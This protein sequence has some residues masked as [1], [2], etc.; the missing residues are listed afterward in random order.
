MAESDS[1]IIDIRALR[2]QNPEE[3]AATVWG[4][5]AEFLVTFDSTALQYIPLEPQAPE[6]ETDFSTYALPPAI[7]DPIDDLIGFLLTNYRQIVYTDVVDDTAN[8]R[9]ITLRNPSPTRLFSIPQDVDLANPPVENNEPIDIDS[10]RKP[11]EY[12]PQVKLVFT[13][14]DAEVLQAA[15]L[16]LGS[17]RKADLQPPHGPATMLPF[18]RK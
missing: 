18:A 10:R 9:T 7:I 3:K 5:V 8:I 2:E 15:T 14:N 11:D 13:Y 17:V 1:K 16:A 12:I 4:P 6:S